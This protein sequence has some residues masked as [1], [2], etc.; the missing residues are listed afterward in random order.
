MIF[1]G[2]NFKSLPEFDSLSFDL[3]ISIDSISGSGSFGFSGSGTD[4]DSRIMNLNFESGKIKDFNKNY[5]GSYFPNKQINFSGD[6]FSGGHV[7]YMNNNVVS[8]SGTQDYFKF[9]RFFYNSNGFNIDSQLKIY[10]EKPI[11]TF[12]LPSYFDISGTYTGSLEKNVEFEIFSGDIAGGH[13]PMLSLDSTDFNP[14]NKTGSFTLTTGNNTGLYS[15]RLYQT[16]LN[17]YT[18]YG[19]FSAPLSFTGANMA[20]ETV[21]ANAFGLAANTM[22]LKN[23][24]PLVEKVSEYDLSYSILSSGIEQ[25]KPVGVELSYHDGYTGTLSGYTGD[26]TIVAGGS[27]YG[28]GT[29][30]GISGGGGTGFQA[31][32]LIDSG[33]NGDG[34]TGTITGLSVIAYGHNYFGPESGIADITGLGTGANILCPPMNYNKDFFKTWDLRTGISSVESFS[35]NNYIDSTSPNAKY[36]DNNYGQGLNLMPQNYTNLNVDV[37]NIPY[38]DTREVIVK[39]RVTGDTFDY[40]EYITGAN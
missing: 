37:Y 26:I 33:E 2:L 32:L 30:M 23:F 19:N 27:G 6:I 7:Y 5:I 36:I 16:F 38:Y 24:D 10:T 8:L 20:I 39:L 15:N 12:S 21:K 11:T 17:L 9:K 14:G 1:S 35:G 28:A 22:N 3:S 4:G 34:S 29:T 13:A 25:Q 40:I 31:L 18:S